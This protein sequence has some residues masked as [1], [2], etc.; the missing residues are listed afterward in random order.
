MCL[1][2]PEP[3]EGTYSQKIVLANGTSFCPLTKTSE[4]GQHHSPVVCLQWYFA[5]TNFSR[6]LTLYEIGAESCLRQTVGV[7]QDSSLRFVRGNIWL[8]TFVDHA[9]TA[10]E[11]GLPLSM[12]IKTFSTMQ[13]S[14]E[15]WLR[16][17][18][19]Q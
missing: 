7:T 16:H 4:R 3:F 10:Q 19:T 17:A 11:Q 18:P 15:K 5:Q 9:N 8:A 1:E 14:N 12:L 6:L 2:G 13:V